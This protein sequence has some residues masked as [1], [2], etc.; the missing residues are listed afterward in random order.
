MN[1]PQP[2][3]KR[4]Y[5]ASSW[6]NQRQPTTVSVLRAHGFMCYDFR[7]PRDEGPYVPNM[8]SAGFGWKQIDVAWQDWTA[9]QYIEALRHPLAEAGFNA[10]YTAMGWADTMV[11]LMP[12]GRSAHL[13]LGWACG[14]GKRT[15]IL[16][17]PDQPAEPELM[18]KMA[19]LVTP[20]ISDLLNW[21]AFP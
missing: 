3:A 1:N 2:P 16:L 8:P 4:I 19:G 10:D 13:E 18:V 9:D 15:A 14:A 17:D 21:L 11:L 12:C 20:S 6:R 5:L 7:H